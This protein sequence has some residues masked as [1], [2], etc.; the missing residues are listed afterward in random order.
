M[1]TRDT[2]R[3][4]VGAGRVC[5]TCSGTIESVVSE[6]G[7]QTVDTWEGKRVAGVTANT[8]AVPGGIIENHP[9]SR[10]VMLP[11][12]SKIA[13]EDLVNNL[14]PLCRALTCE[15]LHLRTL[16]DE[17]V[18]VVAG[19]LRSAVP[20]L[21]WLL[22][23]STRV[24]TYLPPPE[25]G[26]PP[27]SA[28]EEDYK[29]ELFSHRKFKPLLSSVIIRRVP[30]AAIS[31]SALKLTNGVGV[32]AI[33]VLPD[34]VKAFK[35]EEVQLGRQALLAAGM[36]CRIVWQQPLEQVDPCEAQCLFRKGNSLE[37][38]NFR[39]ILEAHSADGVVQHAL[40]ETVK[41]A[42]HNTLYTEAQ[43]R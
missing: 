2:V 30:V 36:G 5:R 9:V 19:S 32:S 26:M 43:T 15:N 24:I 4:Q 20:Y 6:E 14:M 12:T 35:V 21:Q 17:V 18:V 1:M 39:V 7:P 41:R 13:N 22:I 11:E 16:D 37:F 40:L 25:D 38:F 27:E 8:S 42:S 33:A 31:E 23:K 29:H 10:I 34:A 3:L 28:V